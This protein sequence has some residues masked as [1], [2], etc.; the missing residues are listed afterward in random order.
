MDDRLTALEKMVKDGIMSVEAAR[1][2]KIKIYEEI[3]HSMKKDI[4]MPNLTER[5]EKGKLRYICTIPRGLSK[6][7]KRHQVSGDTPEECKEKWMRMVCENATKKAKEPKTLNELML[8]W[9]DRKG[10]GI[11]PQTLAGYHSHFENHIK[12]SAFGQY[13]IKDIKLPE[14]E[15][16][17]NYLT[18]KR[19]KKSDGREVGLGYNTIRHVRSEISMALDYA[20]SHEYIVSN[21]MRGVKI[22]AGLCSD[23]RKHETEA[24]TDEELSK[25]E[26]ESLRLWKEQKKYRYSA[27]IMIL[28]LTGCRAGELVDAT[29][30][31][32]DFEKGTFSI[33]STYISYK[34]Y[35]SGKF[36]AGSSTPKTPGSRR[37]LELT[38]AAL[39][40]FKELKKRNEEAGIKSNRIIVSRSGHTT[41]QRDLNVRFKVFC[42]AIGVQ[43]KS[44]HAGRRTYASILLENNIPLPEVAADLGHK[45]NSTTLDTYY[46][47][48]SKK[49]E[50]FSKKNK[51][52]LATAC[53]TPAGLETR[54][55]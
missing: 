3:I 30:D 37:T 18:K 31:D 23:E 27:A 39:Y 32:V 11:K 34:D 41:N 19:E 6:D 8:E 22:N 54:M 16:F 42:D 35:K 40:W 24:W 26:K 43:Y 25:I 53:N 28:A 44:T 46:K 20:V 17:I 15:A 13:K 51:I 9:M 45:K 1:P 33:T 10:E 55:K 47:G 4:E 14:C 49:N 36:I 21:H 12:E 5:N 2:A 48:R 52:F 50:M 29:W 38:D 7:G